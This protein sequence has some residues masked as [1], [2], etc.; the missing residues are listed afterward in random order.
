M[1]FASAFKVY[2]TV[3]GGRFIIDLRAAKASEFLNQLPH[4]NSIFY[5]MD[6]PVLTP[7]LTR[8]ITESSLPLKSVE[9]DFA[10]DSSGFFTYR[11]ERSYDDKH[12]AERFERN[13]GKVHSMCGVKANIVT[14]VGFAGAT[15]TRRF[16][17][18]SLKRHK[19]TSGCP[20]FRLTRRIWA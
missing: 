7:T 2:T 6:D 4:Y 14:A 8:L 18:P 20:K 10:V 19:R 1:V 16:C 11:F 5:L 13:W 3:S 15:P 12:G 17:R 9:R